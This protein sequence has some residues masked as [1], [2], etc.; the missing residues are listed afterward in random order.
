MSKPEITFKMGAVRASIFRNIIQRDG[1]SVSL[2]KV[3]LEVRYRDKDGKWQGTNSLSLND[4]PK[5]ITAL[6][7]AYEYILSHQA[8]QPDAA[9][10]NPTSQSPWPPQ[11]QGKDL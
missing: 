2:P 4:L 1:R 9:S 5:A 10:D 7:K 8:A 6:Q 3:V 11:A